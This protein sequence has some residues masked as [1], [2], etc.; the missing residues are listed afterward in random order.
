MML[1][2][3]VCAVS[4]FNI[5]NTIMEVDKEEPKGTGEQDPAHSP[6][7]SLSS[8]SSSDDDSEDLRAEDSP[9]KLKLIY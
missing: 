9:S 7:L 8:G 2:E 4:K 6:L 3:M 1:I 5:I